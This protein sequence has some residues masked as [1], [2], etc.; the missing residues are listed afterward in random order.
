[1]FFSEEEEFN[2]SSSTPSW[3]INLEYGNWEDGP[4]KDGSRT[5][6]IA[7]PVPQ[8]SLINLLNWLIGV[9]NEYHYRQN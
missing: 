1:M 2:Y 4:N 8:V 7:I 5:M 6:D 3:N 9:S